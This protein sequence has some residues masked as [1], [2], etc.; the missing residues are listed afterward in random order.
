[1]TEQTYAAKAV[2]CLNAATKIV[3]ATLPEP[4]EVRAA[5]FVQATN[6]AQVQQAQMTLLAFDA[7]KK[8]AVGVAFNRLMNN[9]TPIPQATE[10]IP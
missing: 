6:P 9:Q 7:L 4:A 2:E 10:I 1:M 5:R 8:Q 3:E